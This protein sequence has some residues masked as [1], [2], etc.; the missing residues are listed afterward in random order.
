MAPLCYQAF[1]LVSSCCSGRILFRSLDER[2]T[3]SDLLI[4]SISELYVAEKRGST[5]CELANLWKA[6]SGDILREHT[7]GNMLQQLM[8]IARMFIFSAKYFLYPGQKILSMR[9]YFKSRNWIKFCILHVS[10]FKSLVQRCTFFCSNFDDSSMY[11]MWN[12]WKK[13]HRLAHTKVYC[14]LHTGWNA[15][16]LII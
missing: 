9:G 3:S 2:F 4:T 15:E 6:R 1:L 14:I 11:E 13:D 7:A 12:K 10:F 16:L 8:I 5:D